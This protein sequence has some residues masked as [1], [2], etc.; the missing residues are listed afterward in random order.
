MKL[1]RLFITCVATA[2]AVLL[3]YHNVAAD[4]WLDLKLE[5][6]QHI[7]KIINPGTLLAE[8]CFICGDPNSPIEVY[9][10]RSTKT[11]AN[12]NGSYVIVAADRVLSATV[13]RVSALSDKK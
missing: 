12:N 1:S 10:V 9:R 6:A 11:T 4:W 2:T 5:E 7:A 13:R 3:P 8:Y